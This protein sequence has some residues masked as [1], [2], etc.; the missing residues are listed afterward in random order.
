[1]TK[2]LKKENLDEI[3]TEI[4]NGEIV[5]F[6][7]ETVFGIGCRYGDQEALEKLFIAK[8]RDHSKAIT[9][10]LS[11]VEDLKKYAYVDASIMNVAKTF[12]P[13]RI[14]LILKK[15]PEV[16]DA[17]T[18]GLP[19]IGI[20]IPD[21]SFVLDLIDRTGPLLVTSANLSSHENTTN[22]KEVLAQLNG[23][24]AAV[25]EGQT[26]SAQAST[27]VS[28]IDGQMKILRA[29]PI[30]EKEIKEAFLG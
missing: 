20:R 23:R 30:T 18:N 14:T 1:M 21:S 8:N 10:M 22:E 3:V 11:R 17:M 13:G 7:T 25:V 9:L 19:T 4:L 26:S 2:V 28:L 16:D 15:R 6:P 29:G 12:M 27:V 24:I 5:A